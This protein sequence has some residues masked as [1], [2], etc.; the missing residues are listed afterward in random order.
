MLAA[1]S[2]AENPPTEKKPV[3][4]EYHGVKVVDDYRW[5][6]DA[7]TPAVKAWTQVQ[8]QRT[9]AWLD[10]LPDRAAIQR[11]LTAWFAKDSPSYGWLTSRPGLPCGHISA[12]FRKLRR[13]AKLGTWSIA[14]CATASSAGWNMISSTDLLPCLRNRV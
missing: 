13:P 10:A 5:L 8:N 12:P 1:M 2:H 11:Q 6:E 7:D 14:K 4:D 3:T 9:R